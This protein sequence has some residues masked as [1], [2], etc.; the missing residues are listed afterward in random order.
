[1]SQVR[2]QAAATLVNKM[3][4]GWLASMS[5]MARRG[6]KEALLTRQCRLGCDAEETN[7]HVLAECK[8]SEV[9]GE[10]RHCV[11]AVHQLVATMDVSDYAK[12]IMGLSWALDAEVC[13]RDRSTEE[14]RNFFDENL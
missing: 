3:P 2:G 11:A 4:F 10:R 7:W 6:N 1:M 5:V 12:K 9:V 13:V 14:G 8:H